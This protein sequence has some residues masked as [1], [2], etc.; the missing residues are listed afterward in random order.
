[1]LLRYVTEPGDYVVV[2][3]GNI[4]GHPVWPERRYKRLCHRILAAVP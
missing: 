3:D 2:E 1:M 4:N